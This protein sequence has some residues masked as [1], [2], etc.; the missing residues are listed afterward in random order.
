MA[1]IKNEPIPPVRR[2]EVEPEA[3]FRKLYRP[4]GEIAVT[5]AD[6]EAQV[7]RTLN[8]LLETSWREGAALEWFMQ[9]FNR[10]IELFYFLASRPIEWF[11]T[12]NL[13]AAQQQRQAA[14]NQIRSAANTLYDLLRQANGDRNNLL[15]GAWTGLSPSDGSYSK[16]RLRAEAGKLSEIPVRGITL[17][18]LKQEADFIISVNMR[19]TDWTAR[20]R[21]R[22]RPDLWPAP[23]PQRYLLHSPI[24]SLIQAHRKRSRQRP[25]DASPP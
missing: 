5:F 15:H 16:D 4:L 13:T 17:D 18:I 1:W 2:A 25:P 20:Y 11:P 8:V 9:S 21:R 7:T 6:M 14:H 19:L 23:L 22:D 12:G 10:R 24:T 3:I